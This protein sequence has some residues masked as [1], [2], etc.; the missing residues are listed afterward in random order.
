MYVR[1]R[2]FHPEFAGRTCASCKEWVYQDD[3]TIQLRAGEPVKRFRGA[4]TPCGT[5]PKIP[6]GLPKCPESAVEP[7]EKSARIYQHYR[8]CRAVARF[9]DDPIVKRH[10]AIIRALHDERDRLPLERL[11]VALGVL[12]RGSQH[13]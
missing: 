4:P 7:S 12:T 5:C 13:R 11:T 9:P 10:A 2:L 6:S 8:E 3:G 1:L